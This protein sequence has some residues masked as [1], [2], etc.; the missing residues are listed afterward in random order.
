[1]YPYADFLLDFDRKHAGTVHENRAG[2]VRAAVIVE[3]RPDFFLPKV[4]RNVMYFL[5]TRWN[6]YVVCSDHSRG[7]VQDSLPGWKAEFLNLFGKRIRL[8]TAEYSR[9]MMSPR[10]W[11]LFPESKLLVFQAD[12]LLSAPNIDEFINYDYVGA[13]CGRLDE[14]YVACGGLSLRTRQVMLDCLARF[15]P[16]ADVP[17]DVFFTKA[18]RQS[19]GSMPDVYTASRFC[20][21]SVYSAHPVG[22]HGTDKYFHDEQVAKKI[23]SAILY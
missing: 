18:V 23:T 19:G 6:L 22:V 9:V 10:F 16:D 12:S 14:H 13:P 15:R 17:E 4:V 2:N 1:M 5:G 3:T 8:S 20:V 21:E 7:Y 11:Q